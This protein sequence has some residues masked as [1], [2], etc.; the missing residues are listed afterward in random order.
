MGLISNIRDRWFE[1]QD[2]YRQYLTD[3]KAK[4]RFPKVIKEVAE[5]RESVFNQYNIR[6]SDN[7]KQVVYVITIPEEYQLKGQSWQIMDKL[8]ENSY[9][10]S[11]YL[12]E[13]LGIGDH[14]SFPEYY[15][16]E[17]PSQ[18]DIPSCKYLSIWT[19]EPVLKTKKVPYIINTICTAL[20]AGIIGGITA[21]VML[22]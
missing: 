3:K 8:N 16:L 20:A 7:Y 2:T 11:K 19:Y 13:D 4:K 14:L 18:N 1:I 5:D 22:L 15:H 21:L 6:Y 17:D 12:R 9:F 10:I